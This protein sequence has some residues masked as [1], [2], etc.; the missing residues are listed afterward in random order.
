MKFT[1]FVIISTK[2]RKNPSW[3]YQR[4][5]SNRQRPFWKLKDFQDHLKS[6]SLLRLIF[7]RK[8]YVFFDRQFLPRFIF[9]YEAE[10]SL[11]RVMKWPVNFKTSQPAEFRVRSIMT[12][13]WSDIFILLPQHCQVPVGQIKCIKKRH[14]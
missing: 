10:K 1:N 3:I 6:V 14:F 5:I 9:S 12:I 7:E 2:V 13:F 4:S 11:W 8:Y